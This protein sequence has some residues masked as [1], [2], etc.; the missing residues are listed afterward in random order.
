MT[1]SL[2]GRGIASLLREEA[3][4]KLRQ[5]TRVIRCGPEKRLQNP[6]FSLDMDIVFKISKL[7]VLV[8]INTQK[9][10][11]MYSVNRFPSLLR[12]KWLAFQIANRN[13]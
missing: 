3:A 10:G 13:T 11:L 7:S 2:L 12:C 9:R 4:E 8:H 6:C 1:L 5:D